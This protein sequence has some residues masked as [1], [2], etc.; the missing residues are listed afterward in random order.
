[1]VSVWPINF[2]TSFFD[3]IWYM[4]ISCFAVEKNTCW[5]N[6]VTAI[7]K[8]PSAWSMRVINKFS[9]DSSQVDRG[10]STGDS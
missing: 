5:L 4:Q 9:G 2:R 7:L 3:G 10:T 6:E 1:M 8:I